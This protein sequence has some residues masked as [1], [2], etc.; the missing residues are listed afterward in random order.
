MRR[1]EQEVTWL[2]LKA[3]LPVTRVIASR[4]AARDPQ[5]PCLAPFQVAPP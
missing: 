5:P 1:R 2:Q 3:Q 4:S